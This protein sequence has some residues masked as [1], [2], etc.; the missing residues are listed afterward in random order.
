MVEECRQCI[1]VLK[2]RVLS[3]I[4]GTADFRSEPKIAN[5]S[6]WCVFQIGNVQSDRIPWELGKVI[7][8]LEAVRWISPVLGVS[9]FEHLPKI[10]NGGVGVQFRTCS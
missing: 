10:F 6:D 3:E 9:G 1:A 2:N 8:F 5:A 7:Q 4:K